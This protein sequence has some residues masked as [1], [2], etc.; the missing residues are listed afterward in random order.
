M[1]A[2][3]LRIASEDALWEAV[4]TVTSSVGIYLL[5]IYISRP[6]GYDQALMAQPPLFCSC[7]LHLPNFFFPRYKTSSLIPPRFFF[8]LC[9]PLFIFVGGLKSCSPLASLFFSLSPLL[10]ITLDKRKKRR[11]PSRM[12]QIRTLSILYD[13]SAPLFHRVSFPGFQ[14]SFV[15]FS[16]S[17]CGVDDV[18]RSHLASNLLQ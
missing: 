2:L 1:I 5:V 14:F 9:V 13:A 4:S 8:P 12:L 3:Q 7:F 18:H 15:F 6:G 16:L 11:G 10:Y 17:S